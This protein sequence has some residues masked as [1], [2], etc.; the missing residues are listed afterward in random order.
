MPTGGLW[1]CGKPEMGMWESMAVTAV[2]AKI[3]RLPF[4]LSSW[5][6]VRDQCSLTGS[7]LLADGDVLHARSLL[8]LKSG[9]GRKTPFGD[10]RR[11]ELKLYWC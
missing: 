4:P 8:R 2:T 9:S 6:S 5:L 11:S 1:V 7:A 10:F 3:T